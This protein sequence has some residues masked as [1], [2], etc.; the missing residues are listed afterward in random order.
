[1]PSN[2][3]LIPTWIAFTLILILSACN[4]SG[5]GNGSSDDNADNDDSSASMT[6]FSPSLY[7]IGND[8]SSGNVADGSQLWITEGTES[9]TSLVKAIFPGDD[10]GMREFTRVGDLMFFTADDGSGHDQQ[11]WV[12]DGT[13]SGTQRLTDSSTH[14]FARELTH[15]DEMLYF[16]A[17]DESIDRLALWTSDGTVG[18]TERVVANDLTSDSIALLTSFN[19][20][21]F[22]AYR[23][24][25]GIGTEL[26]RSRP[27]GSTGVFANI[28][29]GGGLG[30]LYTCPDRM[31][32]MNGYL[33]FSANDGVGGNNCALWRTNGQR[34]GGEGHVE[35]VMDVSPDST[36][37]GPIKMV[38]TDDR[39]FFLTR[40]S[41]L[42][43]VDSAIWVSDGT[44]QGTERVFASN[45][46]YQVLV[47]DQTEPTGHLMG[48]GGY[49]YF[50]VRDLNRH[51]SNA[52][53][54]WVTDGTEAELFVDLERSILGDHRISKA[55]SGD[56]LYYLA[57]RPDT[58]DDLVTPNNG[59]WVAEGKQTTL[60]PTGIRTTGT[61]GIP[62]LPAGDGE[63][64]IF[65]SQ[66]EVWRTN[67]TDQGT[68]FVKEICSGPCDGFL[69][70]KIYE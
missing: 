11:L 5:G 65:R 51:D 33:Y 30:S 61:S 50:Y 52:L 34:V 6:A 10:A 2:D 48:A 26:W 25:A 41:S 38:A 49:A 17:M 14:K 24:S 64:L 40:G 13:E 55:V 20:D 27:G 1:M 54:L 35:K 3:K 9:T 68:G 46:D 60:L 67:G 18:G 15:V 8:G 57:L 22:F 62:L 23:D 45:D 42:E 69:G 47:G 53:Q 56:R 19:D 63:T 32:E 29:A 39:L 44:E 16:R 66:S 59:L 31:V 28:Q 4:S 7:L 70:P 58:A 12:S 21:L 37:F 43:D 36:N